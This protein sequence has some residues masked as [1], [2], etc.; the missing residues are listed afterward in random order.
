MQDQNAIEPI[1]SLTNQT[2]KKAELHS[3]TVKE[4]SI[5]QSEIESMAIDGLNAAGLVAK[6]ISLDGARLSR[7][8]LKNVVIEH[9]DCTNLVI[10]GV[11]IGELLQNKRR[12]RTPGGVGLR[13]PTGMA[14][15]WK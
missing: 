15:P 3:C 1:Y 12:P 4:T 6:S 13:R 9:A 14:S 2:L 11:N 10:N 5:S 7:V 8:S